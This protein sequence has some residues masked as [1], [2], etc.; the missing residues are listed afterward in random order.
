MVF[1]WFSYG[2]R[3]DGNQEILINVPHLSRG[4]RKPLKIRS[5]NMDMDSINAYK[6]VIK[7]G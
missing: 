3:W 2:F 4:P 7:S 6:M 5:S 1:L